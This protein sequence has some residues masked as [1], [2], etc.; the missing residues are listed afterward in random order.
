M[1]T[2]FFAYIYIDFFCIC[3]VCIPHLI[4]KELQD[5]G[6]NAAIDADE[7]VDGGEDHVGSA[8]DGE[9]EGGWVHEWSDRPTATETNKNV[10]T[11]RCRL[12]WWISMVDQGSFA[13]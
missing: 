10:T 13:G 12:E 11:D 1:L 2:L 9:D 5:K 7:E 3:V 4:N 8:R 6:G